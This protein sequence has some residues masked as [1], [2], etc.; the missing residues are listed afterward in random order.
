LTGARGYPSTDPLYVISGTDVVS[1]SAQSRAILT[2][3]D[4]STPGLGYSE[5]ETSI[6]AAI[7]DING[8]GHPEIAVGSSFY[9]VDTGGNTHGRVVVFDGSTGAKLYSIEPTGEN[10]VYFGNNIVV[11]GDMNADGI[12]DLIVSAQ[13]FSDASGGP[14]DG[15]IIGYSG[16]NGTELFRH[17][18]NSER[19]GAYEIALIGDLNGDGARELAVASPYEA[20]IWLSH[21]QAPSDSSPPVILPTLT[22]TLG[23]NGW[24]VSNVG[25]SWSV[26]DDGSP[27]T[28]MIGCGVTTVAS[29]SGGAGFTCTAT[30][31]GGTAHQSVMVKRDATSPLLS[32]SVSPD[33][34]LLHGTGTAAAN[35]SDALSGVVSQ[36]CSGLDTSSAG[37]HTTTCNATDGAGNTANATVMYSVK[38]GFVGFTS[39]VDNPAVVNVANAGQAIPFK[40]RLVDS[41][42][43]AITNLTSASLNAVSIVCGT[44]AV[45]DPVEQYSPDATPLQNLGDGYYQYNWKSPKSYQ[46]SCKR[47]VLGLGDGSSHEALFRFK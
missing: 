34:L 42:G 30:S 38:F 37:N 35:A 24:Y 29:D 1:G 3:A 27:I 40:W 44:G 8:D 28:M 41:N 10:G 25:V 15:A 21:F 31:S 18:G 26:T 2:L 39:P 17:Y 32:P 4:A 43:A 16:L 14:D 22:G 5:D 19:I 45:T 11:P 46:D 33:P 7:G 36:G 47:L 23:D 12:D 9:R 6:A 20:S 13:G